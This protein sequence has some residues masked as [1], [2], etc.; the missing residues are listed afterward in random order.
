M[1]FIDNRQETQELRQRQAM[2][3]QSL[4]MKRLSAQQAM[5]DNNPRQMALRKERERLVGSAAQRQE[6]IEDEELF[7]GKIS[8]EQKMQGLGTP[9]SRAK[10]VPILDD[11][12]LE[13]K[14][15]VMRERALQMHRSEKST[16][17]FPIHSANPCPRVPKSSGPWHQLVAQRQTFRQAAGINPNTYEFIALNGT[18]SNGGTAD[19]LKAKNVVKQPNLAKALIH[20][21]E[22]FAEVGSEARRL[23]NNSPGSGGRPNPNVLNRHGTNIE[24]FVYMIE[25]P[26]KDGQIDK[27]LKLTYEF[28]TTR[29]G[30]VISQAINDETP[31]T[32]TTGPT[33]AN[34]DDV[35]LADTYSSTHADTGTTKIATLLEQN[36]MLTRRENEER[37]DARTKLAGEGARFQLVRNR[38]DR[39]A[40]NSRIYTRGVGSDRHVYWTTFSTLWLNW[41]SVFDSA[42]DIS[43]ATVA[44]KLKDPTANWTVPVTK[45]RSSQWQ[46]KSTDIKVE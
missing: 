27:T 1:S 4:Q 30:Y 13:H 21:A 24:V 11:S 36:P 12:A 28:S 34:P 20:A 9:A 39:L 26:F 6:G 42:Y 32:I 5:I 7:Q 23:V 2:I 41:L 40:N 14:A 22:R 15:G 18:L 8:S 17:D 45:T 31:A 10:K 35:G 44:T 16:F 33:I 19:L 46:V 43:D 37:L 25:I 38:I 3:Q 29:P